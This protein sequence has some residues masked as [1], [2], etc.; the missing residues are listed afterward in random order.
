M[1]KRCQS[2]IKINQIYFSEKLDNL[3]LSSPQEK[4]L[5]QE[6]LQTLFTQIESLLLFKTTSYQSEVCALPKFSQLWFLNETILFPNIQS[7]HN[8][9]NCYPTY[10][11]ERYDN[12]TNPHHF[13]CSPNA[14]K[15]AVF[16][17][18]GEIRFST[19]QD[20]DDIQIVTQGN[21]FIFDFK[22]KKVTLLPSKGVSMLIEIYPLKT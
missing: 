11:L 12:M 6:S 14:P 19:K 21:W 10:W 20:L 17:V 13:P 7:K 3:S 1:F 9:S 16:C 2:K 18:K 22:Q 15:T 5:S 4:L 8:M